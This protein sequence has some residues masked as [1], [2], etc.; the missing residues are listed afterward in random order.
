[1]DE[2]KDRNNMTTLELRRSLNTEHIKVEV[3]N[4]KQR[5]KRGKGKR[6]RFP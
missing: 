6:W 1:L 3:C 2:K 5:R 4:E